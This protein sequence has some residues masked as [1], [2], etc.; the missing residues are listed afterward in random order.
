MR[1]LGFE[2]YRAGADRGRDLSVTAR[3]SVLLALE[4][5]VMMDHVSVGFLRAGPKVRTKAQLRARE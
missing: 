1:E 4:L 5:D 3:A 2:N